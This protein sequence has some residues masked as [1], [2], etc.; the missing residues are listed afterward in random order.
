MMLLSGL[1]ANAAQITPTKLFIFMAT[2]CCLQHF[3]SWFL[4]GPVNDCQGDPCGQSISL[5]PCAC[6]W[7]GP[8]LPPGQAQG[9]HRRVPTP[10]VPTHASSA[11][12]TLHEMY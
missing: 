2:I 8:V 1:D 9:P 4:T 10:P 12:S 5:K 7:W 3:A 11:R 6:P